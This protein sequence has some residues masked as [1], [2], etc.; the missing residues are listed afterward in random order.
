M[1][2]D[3]IPVQKWWGY[4]HTNGSVQAKAYFSEADLD[5]A[6]ESDFV[7]EVVEPFDCRGRDEALRIVDRKTDTLC[8]G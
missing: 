6:R 8:S 1:G 2:S 3:E 7:A 4:R 5:D